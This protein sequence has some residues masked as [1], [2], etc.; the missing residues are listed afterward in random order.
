MH[1]IRPPHCAHGN[2]LLQSCDY[3]ARW[4]EIKW[5]G[6]I[7]VK[8]D[9]SSTQGALCMVSVFLILHF[10]YLGGGAY[11]PNAPPC[12]RAWTT[13]VSKN[14]NGWSAGIVCVAVTLPAATMMTRT[15][16]IRNYAACS[17]W[18]ITGYAV[19]KALDLLTQQAAG[20]NPGQS[21]FTMRC[22]ASVEL[23][24]ATALWLKQVGSTIHHTYTHNR[25]TALCPGLPGWAGSRKVKP[26][27]I[28]LKQETV[29]GSGI[30]WVIC[31]SAPGSW[32]IPMPALHHSGFYRP[33]A[34]P[35]TEPAVSKH[36]MQYYQNGWINPA[37]LCRGF[38]QPIPHCVIKKFGYL[39]KLLFFSLECCP[40][41]WT[42]GAASGKT[43][44]QKNPPDKTWPWNSCARH[45]FGISC[46]YCHWHHNF[47]RTVH[48]N[49]QLYIY[50]KHS[51]Y[52]R[53][54]RCTESV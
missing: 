38:L 46:S 23:V 14:T 13:T 10:T 51:Y 45:V 12:L 27:W 50:T 22:Y 15:A 26:V 37:V 1:V 19:A 21:T 4:Q 29:S 31:K 18:P 43:L 20:S 28:L 16:N 32:Q 24:L 6:V 34:F 41:L 3:Q 8:V 7:F 40:K 44:L 2:M 35:A 25:L 53:T 9:L 17:I 47:C 5:G 39:K 52:R 30:S 11:A 49:F 48:L 33:D 36:W 42:H 54:A